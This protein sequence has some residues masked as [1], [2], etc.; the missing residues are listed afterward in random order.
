MLLAVTRPLNITNAHGTGQPRPV[1][2]S[3]YSTG[4]RKT[5]VRRTAD[6]V[7]LSPL[8]NLKTGSGVHIPSYSLSK[9]K[10]FR[11]GTE[12]VASKAGGGGGGRI[13]G[14]KLPLAHIPL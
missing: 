12:A 9:E 10:S 5:T 13:N 2:W 1:L 3:G 14:V 7:N 11:R 6:T 4:I 8:E